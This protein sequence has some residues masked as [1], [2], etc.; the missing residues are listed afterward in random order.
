MSLLP[1]QS[2]PVSPRKQPQPM[3][4]SAHSPLLLEEEDPFDDTARTISE[5]R[6]KR[7]KRPSSRS[8]LIHGALIFLYTVVSM[9]VMR[10]NTADE[11]SSHGWLS[12]TLRRLAID[13]ILA[14][15]RGMTI[16]YRPQLFQN[17]SNNPFAGP[18]SPAIDEAWAELLAPMNIRASKAELDRNDQTSVALPDG[19]GYLA[20]LGVFHEL[21]CIASAHSKER[22]QLT[23]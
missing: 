19:G 15:I 23:S 21:H 10:T 9:M 3:S 1:Q 13:I 16:E 20:W 2:Q 5:R 12:V 14:A 4:S 6:R 7:T 22:P 18:P 8:I 17:L 11:L